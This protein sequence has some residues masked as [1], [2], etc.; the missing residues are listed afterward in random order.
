MTVAEK[1]VISAKIPPAL[2]EEIDCVASLLNVPT[3]SEF[4][5]RAVRLYIGAFRSVEQQIISK[6]AE[7]LDN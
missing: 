6:E 5:E 3:R 2:A 7:G 1:V 4:I